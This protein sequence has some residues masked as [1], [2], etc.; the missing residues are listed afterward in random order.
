V[1][2]A[3]VI[4]VAGL[5]ARAQDVGYAGAGAKVSFVAANRIGA[6]I[7]F[8]GHALIRI[9]LERAGALDLY[10]NVAMWYGVDEREQWY[11]YRELGLF[12]VAFNFDTRYLLPLPD[13]IKVRPFVGAGLAP[14]I[15]HEEWSF[16]PD[17]T[18]GGAA[19]NLF[20]GTDLPIGPTR[21]GFLEVRGKF[22]GRYTALKLTFGIVFTP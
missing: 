4:A 13:H 7:G 9:G 21:Q 8:G 10:P 6:G 22:S 18:R 17:Y 19:F 3:L 16:G 1:W 20:A 11:P 5:P 2:A 14:I 12:E 15:Y